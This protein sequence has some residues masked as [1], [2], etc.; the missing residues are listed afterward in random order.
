MRI[1]LDN[2]CFNRPYDDQ[3]FLSIKLETE[4]K[5]NIQE[6]IKSGQI[7]LALGWSHILDFENNANPYLEKRFEIQEWKKIAE[8]FAEE[9]EDILLK[10]NEF[11]SIGLK[12]LDALHIGM[13]YFT[14]M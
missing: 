3:S 14:G 12:P 2:C 8:S 9:T 5:L 11:I 7:A 1:Y 6:R 4:A 10:M 13:C